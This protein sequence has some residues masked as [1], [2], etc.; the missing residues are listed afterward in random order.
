[1]IT[2][3]LMNFF[4]ISTKYMQPIFFWKNVTLIHNNVVS[5]LQKFYVG[6]KKFFLLLH[7]Y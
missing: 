1:M 6:L 5:R 3:D 4:K 7:N 2:V